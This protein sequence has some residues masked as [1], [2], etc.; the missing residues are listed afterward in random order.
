MVSVVA[1]STPARQMRSAGSCAEQVGHLAAAERGAAVLDGDASF[2]SSIALTVSRGAFGGAGRPGRRGWRGVVVM[3]G[4]R[5]RCRLRG[6]GSGGEH[7]MPP[8]V[9]WVFVIVVLLGCSSH[10][11]RGP[12]SVARSRAA[13]SPCRP[14]SS[15]PVP[16]TSRGSRSFRRGRS[17]PASGCR[18]ITAAMARWMRALVRH[19]CQALAV[20]DGARQRSPV[21]HIVSNTSLA[22]LPLIAPASIE[23]HQRRPGRAGETGRRRAAGR[24]PSAC[25]GPRSS[26]SSRPP[27]RCRCP[28]RPPRN[29]RPLRERG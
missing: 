29:S 10:P 8:A 14:S 20:D 28:G 26:P 27:W 2:R 15:S 17:R 6:Q 21:A 11:R 16:R 24:R 3:S 7:G 23:P 22:V 13:G 9:R 4:G 1:W 25:G 18:A 12:S 5:R 19:L